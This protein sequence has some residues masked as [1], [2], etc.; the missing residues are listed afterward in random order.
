M[1]HDTYHAAPRC[2]KLSTSPLTAEPTCEVIFQLPS[3]LLPYLRRVGP[4]DTPPKRHGTNTTRPGSFCLLGNTRRSHETGD[5]PDHLLLKKD[6]PLDVSTSHWGKLPMSSP[7]PAPETWTLEPG[8]R[9]GRDACFGEQKFS[10]QRARSFCLSARALIRGDTCP[11]FP[12][13][14]G[15]GH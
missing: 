7:N 8:I 14:L 6:R 10:R 4:P 2:S 9:S 15:A 13:V 5:E 12:P 11:T 3:D 1:N